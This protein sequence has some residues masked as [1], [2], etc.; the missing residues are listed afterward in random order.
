MGLAALEIIMK[1][2]TGDLF[3]VRQH[4]LH[5]NAIAAVASVVV[6]NVSVNDL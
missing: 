5:F 3:A 6:M 4:T 2:I 1:E